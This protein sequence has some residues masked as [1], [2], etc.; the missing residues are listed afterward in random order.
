MN[1]ACLWLRYLSKNNLE[2]PNSNGAVRTSPLF[3]KK[4]FKCCF[5]LRATLT[6]LEWS[7]LMMVQ[8]RANDPRDPRHDR[9]SLMK[10]IL[11]LISKTEIQ[12]ALLSLL[13]HLPRRN[14]FKPNLGSATN[15]RIQS[16]VERLIS[17][18]HRRSIDRS[19]PET[20]FTTTNIS[21][22]LSRKTTKGTTPDR[23]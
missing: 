21:F 20:F 14:S 13:S 2:Q 7:I 4:V 11:G 12:M 17:T 19:I 1:L 8:Q 16:L 18:R 15:K 6:I 23:F 5:R 3:C 22:L 10:R 9:F